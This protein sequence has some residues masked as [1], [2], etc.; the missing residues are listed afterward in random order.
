MIFLIDLRSQRGGTLTPRTLSS[1]SAFTG[2]EGEEEGWEREMRDLN[3]GDDEVS[4]PASSPQSHFFSPF[5]STSI[6]FVSPPSPNSLPI[7][8]LDHCPP[9][10]CARESRS[11]VQRP[12][13]LS[14]IALINPMSGALFCF[15]PRPSTPTSIADSALGLA[16][17]PSSIH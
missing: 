5:T 6:R 1:L 7:P 15:H 2:H 13:S 14:S 8:C 16:D 10:F 17:N 4:P 3:R 12:L 11:L 9:F